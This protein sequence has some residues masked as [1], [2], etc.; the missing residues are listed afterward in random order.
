MGNISVAALQIG[1]TQIASIN[2]MVVMNSATIVKN[3]FISQQHCKNYLESCLG[4]KNLP[5]LDLTF[6][7][8]FEEAFNSRFLKIFEKN[9]LQKI[10]DGFNDNIDIYG[11]KNNARILNQSW[12]N[13]GFRDHPRNMAGELLY[14]DTLEFIDRKTAI[15][16]IGSCFAME[17]AYWLQKNGY[18]YLIG[19][20]STPDPDGLFPRSVDIGNIYNT[21]SLVQLLRWALGKEERPFVF[22]ETN[23]TLIDPFCEE[24]PINNNIEAYFSKI[25]NAYN[26]LEKILRNAEVLILTFGL[27]E[28]YQ[29][30]PT[31]HYMFRIPNGL[32]P[33]SFKKKFLSV[34]ENYKFIQE[35]ICLIKEINPTCKFILSVSPVP[36]MRSWQS[37]KHI[38]EST[39]LSKATLRL[40]AE[41]VSQIDNVHYFPSFETAMYP[42]SSCGSVFKKNERH[43]SPELV[44]KIMLTFERMFCKKQNYSSP[45][46]ISRSNKISSNTKLSLEIAHTSFDDVKEMYGLDNSVIN[47]LHDSISPNSIIGESNSEL[48]YRWFRTVTNLT[49]LNLNHIQGQYF[50][51]FAQFT[52]TNSTAQIASDSIMKKG[53][54]LLR[55]EDN[56]RFRDA[57]TKFFRENDLIC[58]K[59]NDRFNHS[60]IVAED[61]RQSV[62]PGCIKY[63]YDSDKLPKSEIVNFLN[64]NLV[65]EI[66]RSVLGHVGYAN[67]GGWT[68]IHAPADDVALSGA[69]LKYHYDCDN[70]GKWIKAF[71]FLN[72]VDET[73]GAH[74]FVERSHYNLDKSFSGDGRFE[75]DHVYSK[76]PNAS[77]AIKA[78]AG[79]ILLAD[80]IGLHKGSPVLSGHRDLVEVTLCQTALGVPK[81]ESVR[82]YSEF[83]ENLGLTKS[84]LHEV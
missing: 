30:L 11:N 20:N 41:Q 63:I 49:Q 52:S 71:I 36:L 54:V 80:T 65:P 2:F 3:E 8:N 22:Y 15:T 82:V 21:P 40:A 74:V 73:N 64:A 84:F 7:I 81:P 38:A 62:K 13:P 29:F 34:E 24:I 79:D 61:F 66:V 44:G 10:F 58:S 31:M 76:Y 35:A 83:L 5:S 53:W 55:G 47:K 70:M 17:L 26:E 16:S 57:M 75:D 78:K 46:W 25:K 1:G 60:S 77:K 67:L 39:M 32:N 59:T 51:A 9:D 6:P 37:D 12:P 33:F 50:K 43:V 19:K 56:C 69:A 4:R 28:V 48:A 27:N 14:A 45:G 68:N 23:E 18:N 72:D 42:G